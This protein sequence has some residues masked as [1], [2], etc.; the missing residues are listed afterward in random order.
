MAKSPIQSA[1]TDINPVFDSLNPSE[2][3]DA[4]PG[5][6]VTAQTTYPEITQS[7]LIVEEKSVNCVWPLPFSEGKVQWRES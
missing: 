1:K 3:D 7:D 5:A 4:E 2:F 6:P